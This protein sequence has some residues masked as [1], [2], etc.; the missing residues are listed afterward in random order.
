MDGKVDQI[1][2]TS[3]ESHGNISVGTL[4]VPANPLYVTLEEPRAQL[5][6]SIQHLEGPGIPAG[7]AGLH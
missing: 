1:E 5:P 7:E 4:G 3:I 6:V 2:D